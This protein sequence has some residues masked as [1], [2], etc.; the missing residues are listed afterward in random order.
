MSLLV[1]SSGGKSLGRYMHVS[2]PFLGKNIRDFKDRK[3][4]D[5]WELNG[6]FSHYWEKSGTRNSFFGIRLGSRCLPAS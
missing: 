6:K 4:E 1:G 3:R 5:N 2:E